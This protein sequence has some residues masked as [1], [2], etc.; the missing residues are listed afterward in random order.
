VNWE[1]AS[2]SRYQCSLHAGRASDGELLFSEKNIFRLTALFKVPKYEI[3]DLLDSLYLSPQSSV[4]D[5]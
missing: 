5:P 4:T 2:C 1:A 3:F